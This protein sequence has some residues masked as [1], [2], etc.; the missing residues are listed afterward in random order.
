MTFLNLHTVCSL[1][2]CMWCV[3][4]I[5]SIGEPTVGKGQKGL[6]PRVIITTDFPPVEVIPIGLNQGPADRRSDPDD[7]QSMVRF[8]LYANEFEVE[9]LVA[10]SA[11]LA[12]VAR[13]RNVLEILDLY[14]RVDEHLRKHDKR[15][16]TA[17]ALRSVTWAGYDG[18]WGKPAPQILGDGKDSEASEAIIKIVDRSDSRPLWVCVWGGSQELAQ[19]IWKVRKTRAP[20][21][22]ERFLSKLRVYLIAKQD[23]TAQWLLD[24]FP[25]LF[26]I[27][28]Q[29]NYMGMFWNM[30][31]SDPALAD[32][33][34]INAN[35][36]EGH[37]PL[38][39]AYPKSGFNP[40]HPGQQEG[41]TPSFLHLV[42]GLRGVNDPE[43]PDQGGWGG[44]FVRPDSSRN[45][46]FDDP[47]GPQ[48]V[49]KWRMEVQAEFARRADWMAGAP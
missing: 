9:G 6:R 29:T 23:G 37:G 40:A 49:F 45:H 44:R 18:A 16:P 33:A 12:N 4:G 42:S 21:E 31:G 36:R 27:L 46:W 2:G 8:L 48:T 32:L 7:V 20:G 34:W 26:I 30:K 13:K 43:K 5:L 41:D 17:D 10:S 38:G 1:A 24:S 22:L 25:S 28:S 15:Y 39:A 19:A 35:I 14:D 47:A 11:T 3:V